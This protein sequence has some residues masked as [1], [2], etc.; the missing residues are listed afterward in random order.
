VSPAPDA[1][2]L[3]TPVIAG[4]WKM[5]KGPGAT[6]EFFERFKA[7]YSPRP[8]RT[9][10]FFP[11]AISL[12]A[13]LDMVQDRPDLQLGVQNIHW[14]PKGAFTGE[15]SAAMAFDAGARYT[16][17]GHSERRHIFGETD[18]D[19][20]RKTAA[21]LEAGLRPVVCVGET[22]EERREGRVDEVIRRQ[23]AAA[24]AGLDAA[25]RPLIIVAY[26]PVW[27]IGTG[28]TATPADAAAAHAVLRSLL[29]DEL[30]AGAAAAVPILYGGSVKP[31]NAA[32]LLAAS[33]VD[34]LLVGGASL[35]PDSFAAIIE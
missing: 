23:L 32:E 31:E 21:A 29:A 2:P 22:L 10:L 4:N 19:V 13:A 6:R 18:E 17:V 33:D 26:E 3:R 7:R 15:I 24:I 35:D 27:A 9:V 16:L 28:V 1:T 25:Q 34:G 5:H 11:P 30:G 12:A 20:K 14:E 8:D